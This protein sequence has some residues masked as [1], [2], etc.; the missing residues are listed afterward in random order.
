MNVAHV[1]G[2]PLKKVKLNFGKFIPCVLT[3]DAQLALLTFHKLSLIFIDCSSFDIF[4]YGSSN[5]ILDLFTLN[6]I[7]F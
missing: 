6:R 7:I 3:R 4:L 1:K 2:S 5:V